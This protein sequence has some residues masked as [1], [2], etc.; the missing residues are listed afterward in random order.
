VDGARRLGRSRP[1]DACGFLGHIA[2]LL[3]VARRGHKTR[4][5]ALCNSGDAAGSRE[6]AAG[7]GAWA[8]EEAVR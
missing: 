8:L 1:V 2:G 6:R 3:E 7:Y 4:R 5:L